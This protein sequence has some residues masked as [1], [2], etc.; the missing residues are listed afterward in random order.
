MV[1]AGICHIL[2]A[3]LGGAMLGGFLGWVGSLLPP[4]LWRPCLILG[5]AI[6][7]FWHALS[8]RSSYLGRPCQVN[9]RWNSRSTFIELGYFLWGMQ[10]GCGIITLIPY[11]SFVLLLGAQFTAGFF[12]GM[13]SG[14]IF[15]GVREM[16][17]VLMA[18]WSAATTETVRPQ[19]LMNFLP[20]LETHVQHMNIAW[21]LVATPFLILL[22]WR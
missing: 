10:L 18:L 11:S 22:V 14:M 20:A 15:G 12:P 2:G 1:Q 8:Q 16:V 9:R 6:F 4:L 7:A 21:I 13:L 3:A 19:K 17:A 5:L